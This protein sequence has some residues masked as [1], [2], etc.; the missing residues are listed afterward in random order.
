[1]HRNK[2]NITDNK[3]TGKSMSASIDLTP[4]SESSLMLDWAIR[5]GALYGQEVLHAGTDYQQAPRG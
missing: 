3:K 1:M 5:K 4:E 2:I